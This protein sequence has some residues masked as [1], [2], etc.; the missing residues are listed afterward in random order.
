V[1]PIVLPDM[2]FSFLL[3]DWEQYSRWSAPN[4]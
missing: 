4:R 2:V 1:V 3:G